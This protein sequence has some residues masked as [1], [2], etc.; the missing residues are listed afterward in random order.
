MV[1]DVIKERF[2][3]R[4]F[5]DRSV[6]SE[7]IEALLEAA[8]LAPSARNLQVCHFVVLEDEKKR[9]QLTDICKGQKFVSQAPI[10]IAVCA[11]NSDYTMTCGHKANLI[12]AAIVGEHIA[13]QAV[14][15][16]LGSCWIGAFYQEKMAKL[17]DLPKD[18]EVVALL[19]IGYPAT[20]KKPRKLKSIEEISSYNVYKE[21]Q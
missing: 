5:E 19:P 21:S 20:T 4:S 11:T 6:E 1:L 16:G 10:T 13:L 2:S 3:V 18:Y 14:A 9:E 12:D 8:R 17:I 7:K 15:L